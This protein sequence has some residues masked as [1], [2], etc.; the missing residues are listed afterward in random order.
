MVKL[1]KLIMWI[2]KEF[3]ASIAIGSIVWFVAMVFGK[4]LDYFLYIRNIFFAV[5]IIDLLIHFA[6]AV[7]YAAR[8][9]F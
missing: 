3:V 1:I 8:E 2:I 4:E 7:N 9:N 6:K 5:L